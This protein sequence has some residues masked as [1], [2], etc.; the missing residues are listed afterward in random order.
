MDSVTRFLT[1]KLKLMVNE[2]KSRVVKTNEC[3]LLLDADQ[4]S[5]V[6]EFQSRAG[7]ALELAAAFP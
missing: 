5:E 7:E 6:G 1:R 2:H 4:Q 3:T